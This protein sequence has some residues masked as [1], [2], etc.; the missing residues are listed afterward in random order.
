MV[1]EKERLSVN[2]LI[3]LLQSENICSDTRVEQTLI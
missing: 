3:D 1:E 2:G